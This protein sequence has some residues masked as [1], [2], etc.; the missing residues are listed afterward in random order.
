MVTGGEQGAVY[1]GEE[2]WL[3]NNFAERFCAFVDVI[4]E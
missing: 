3:G 1:G 4:I 2:S